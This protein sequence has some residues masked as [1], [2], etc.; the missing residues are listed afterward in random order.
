M[1]NKKSQYRNG[2]DNLKNIF[3][4]FVFVL[5]ASLDNAAIGM[6][7]PL[8]SSIA[9]D[10]GFH[11]SGLGMVSAVSIFVISLS[12]IFWAFLSAKTSRKLL[13]ILGTVIWSISVY[14]TSISHT[15]FHLL[16][17][18]FFTGIGLG[19]ISAIGFS[20]LSDSVSKKWRGTVMSLWAMSQGFGTIAGSLMASTIAPL[21]SWRKPFEV[22]SILGFIFIMLY[23]FI[24][25]PPKG[26]SEPELQEL[27]E[28]GATYEHSIRLKDIH[29][30]FSNKSNLLLMLE[31]L[32]INISN[33]T[34]IWLPTLF[35]ARLEHA[36]VPS[37]TSIVA[38]GFIYAISQAGGIISIYLGYIGD[39]LQ[40]KNLS[41]RALFTA[42]LVFLSC[43]LYVIAINIPLINFIIPAT[44]NPVSVILYLGGQLISN[45]SFIMLILV[46]ILASAANSVN[47]P[48]W[49]AMLIDVNLPEHRAA[50]F[51]IA[52]LVTGTGRAL[53]NALIG[54][55][56][57]YISGFLSEPVNYSASLSF[58]QIFVIPAAIFL[59]L[60]SRTCK[61]DIIEVRKMLSQR[62]KQKLS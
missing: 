46:A 10:L 11:V 41:G 57:A 37:A 30:V 15:F 34:L 52:N 48:N 56:L 50:M 62:A 42:A 54:W 21:F 28:K 13:I 59:I 22:L 16:L 14:I 61:K 53:G 3:T 27:F 6:L 58:S 18:Q 8:F 17:S 55:L 43:P 60:I 25:E 20:I 26:A 29:Y 19:C 35:I 47:Y 44:T 31:T 33:G 45:K 32:L 2:D 39:K 49:L 7:P 40:R 24:E 5:L 12:A 1:K 38:A 9:R 36:G 23:F 51:S 4:I